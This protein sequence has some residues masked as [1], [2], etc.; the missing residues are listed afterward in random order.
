V[1]ADRTLYQVRRHFPVRLSADAAP[2]SNPVTFGANGA[3]QTI[4]VAAAREKFRRAIDFASRKLGP[5]NELDPRAM[6]LLISNHQPLEQINARDWQF[7]R[8]Q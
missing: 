4:M 7:Y 6:H 8:D 5:A 1:R 2:K 3:A